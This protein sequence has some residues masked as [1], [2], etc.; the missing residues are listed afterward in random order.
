[1]ICIC[2][3]L[4]NSIEPNWTRKKIYKKTVSEKLHCCGLIDWIIQFNFPVNQIDIILFIDIT[5]KSI[6]AEKL[7]NFCENLEPEFLHWFNSKFWWTFHNFPM[8]FDFYYLNFM[9]KLNSKQKTDFKVLTKIRS[10]KL[11]GKSL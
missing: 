3:K 10:K 1:M 8:K 6:W 9:L 5:M 4:K 7:Q 2:L 11:Q